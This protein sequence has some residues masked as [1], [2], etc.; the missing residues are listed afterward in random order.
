MPPDNPDAIVPGGEVAFPNNGVIFNTDIGRSTDSEFRLAVPG[1]YLVEYTLTSACAAQTVLSLNG[2]ELGYTLVGSDAIGAP[3]SNTTLI[4][5]T[6]ENALLS[7]IN[8]AASG[9]NL[10]LAQTSGGDAPSTAQL[11]I[12]RLT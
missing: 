11:V 5:T 7:V 10:T 12:I 9:G 3:I 4:T 8:P 1:T 6:T 2:T